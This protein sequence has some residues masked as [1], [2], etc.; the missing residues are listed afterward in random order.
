MSISFNS[1]S[2]FSV[3]FQVCEKYIDYLVSYTFNST[4]NNSVFKDAE[5]TLVLLHDQ[6]EAINSAK[7]NDPINMTITRTLRNASESN[8]EYVITTK[9]TITVG[10]KEVYWSNYSVLN[11]VRAKIEE[12]S[13]QVVDDIL[14]SGS[15][16]SGLALNISGKIIAAEFVTIDDKRKT[17]YCNLDLHYGCPTDSKEVNMMC[18]E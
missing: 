5:Y 6:L 13:T 11:S 2:F 17:H 12:C 14:V 9:Y 3:P 10:I 16:E 7:C 18:G 8:E 1:N 4:V 15:L